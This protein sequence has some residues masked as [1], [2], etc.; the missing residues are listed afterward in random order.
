MNKSPLPYVWWGSSRGSGFTRAPEKLRS[1]PRM[2]LKIE[3]REAEFARGLAVEPRRGEAARRVEM[4][5]G[6]CCVEEG[7]EE[8]AAGG[9]EVGGRVEEEE[10]TP[11]RVE[12]E[13]G[14][15]EEE[16]VELVPMRVE[17]ERGCAGAERELMRVERE[18][19]EE[20]EE[21]GAEEEEGVGM[22]AAKYG[23]ARRFVEVMKAAGWVRLVGAGVFV[24]VGA[25]WCE[26][27][28]VLGGE[29]NAFMGWVGVG[30]GEGEAE[31]T[32]E[33]LV[34]SGTMLGSSFMLTFVSDGMSSG[35]R[36]GMEGCCC[37]GGASPESGGREGRE[38][39]K[40]SATACFMKFRRYESCSFISLFSV[41]KSSIFA[42][43]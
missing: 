42:V 34:M 2:L 25:T 3:L 8:G 10:L 14:C 43:I 11:R 33:W 22:A 27:G 5:R 26:G 41:S 1:V 40:E 24:G 12:I 28:G 37:A 36:S 6:V 21:E 19:A 32:M 30:E 9:V 15:V 39:G 13:R 4:V 38:G 16:W 20:E 18:S 35:K 23:S 31:G 17:T 29:T 7:A